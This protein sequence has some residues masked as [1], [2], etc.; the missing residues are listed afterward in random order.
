MSNLVKIVLLAPDSVATV[1]KIGSDKK[2]FLETLVEDRDKK[3]ITRPGFFGLFNGAGM[4]SNYPGIPSHPGFGIPLSPPV[5]KEL[6]E[7]EAIRNAVQRKILEECRIQIDSKKIAVHT[8]SDDTLP[9]D[10]DFYSGGFL[11]VAIYQ[12]TEYEKSRLEG[13]SM[14][15]FFP[16]GGLPIGLPFAD[17]GVAR[18][19]TT[20]PD[21]IRGFYLGNPN[22]IF[23]TNILPYNPLYP[24]PLY[25]PYLA[26][27]IVKYGSTYL[28]PTQVFEPTHHERHSRSSSRSSSRGRSR[29][30]SRSSKSKREKYLKYK[31][32]YLDLKAKIDKL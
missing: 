26:S 23:P 4:F 27:P 12:L 29:S 7:E 21:I 24:V 16:F 20:R 13:T 5:T 11:H 28:S 17:A 3:I 30:P 18:F 32:K 8:L 1:F 15:G 25:S 6:S 2:E 14:F 31:Q 9:E 22:V 10:L 19:I